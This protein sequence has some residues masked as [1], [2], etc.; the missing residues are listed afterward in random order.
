MYLR[1][2]EN[3]HQDLI[4]RKGLRLFSKTSAWT[5]EIFVSI[6]AEKI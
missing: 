1:Y 2:P 6:K 3:E 4:D 5:V